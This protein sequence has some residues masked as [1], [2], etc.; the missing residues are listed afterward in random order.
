MD[1]QSRE[2]SRTRATILRTAGSLFALWIGI[3]CGESGPDPE[4]FSHHL[5]RAQEAL[6]RG[7]SGLATAD[8]ELRS[9]IAVDPENIEANF[10]LGEVRVQREDFPGAIFYFE[11]TLALEPDHPGAA[12]ALA[13]VLRSRD[14]GRAQELANQAKR[15]APEDPRGHIAEAEL[16][17]QAGRIGDALAAAQRSVELDPALP[18]AQH[19]LGRAHESLYW[20]D[21]LLGR[22][23]DP[24]H[25]EAALSAFDNYATLQGPLDPWSG[26]IAA[27]RV[28]GMWPGRQDEALEAYRELLRDSLSNAPAPTQIH[29]ARAAL[30]FAL[31]MGDMPLATETLE[32]L[33]ELNPHE[34]TYWDELARIRESE[35]PGQGGETLLALLT[36]DPGNPEVHLRYASFLRATQGRR[37]AVEYLTRQ[38]ENERLRPEMLGALVE[39]HEQVGLIAERDK[40]LTALEAEFPLH[41]ISLQARGRLALQE[42]NTRAAV[43]ALRQLVTHEDSGKAQHLL[44]YAEFAEKNYEESLRAIARAVEIDPAQE[45][46]LRRLRAHAAYEGRDCAQAVSNFATLLSQESLEPTDQVLLARCFYRLGEQGPGR[47]VLRDLL[48][49]TDPPIEGIVEFSKREGHNPSETNRIQRVLRL[50][51][52]ENPDHPQLITQ[53]ALTELIRGD[54]ESAQR[55][56]DAAVARGVADAELL[57]LRGRLNLERGALEAARVDLEEV[58]RT[59]PTLPRALSLLVRTLVGLNNDPAAI[60]ALTRAEKFGLLGRDRRAMLGELQ[61]AAGD[62]AGALQNLEI[63]LRQGSRL[64]NVKRNLALL[65]ADEENE[66]ERALKLATQLTATQR[67]DPDAWDILGYVYLRADFNVAAEKLFRRALDLNAAAEGPARPG[68]HYRLGLALEALGRSEEAAAAFERAGALDDRFLRKP[69][70]EL[71]ASGQDLIRTGAAS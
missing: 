67:F 26:R 56:L 1:G 60:A 21:R 8:I 59:R 49:S 53:L 36:E 35:S 31:E 65:L 28:L 54:A 63:A 45:H 41:P 57:L 19:V 62:R 23:S 46:R 64:A 9:A 58:Y 22:A 14:A 34:L 20:N 7:P 69:D 42:G 33:I 38:T 6:S 11:E 48:A 4:R 37:A 3:G 12:A 17:L 43:Q 16:A 52:E 10:L 70:F 18:G 50:S 25:L 47:R 55:R 39:L 51:L 2:R 27:V 40:A 13:I 61:L 5:D 29:L 24:A 68:S 15:V 66:W 32:R 71:P 30:G 44:A